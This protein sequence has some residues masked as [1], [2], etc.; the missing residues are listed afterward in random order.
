MLTINN[1]R[2]PALALKMFSSFLL[3][4]KAE[5]MGYKEYDLFIARDQINSEEKCAPFIMFFK[6]RSLQLILVHS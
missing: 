1:P 6:P 3:K 2:Q 4:T 5:P